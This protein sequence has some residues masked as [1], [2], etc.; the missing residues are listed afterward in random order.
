LS[1]RTNWASG[2][3]GFEKPAKS[4]VF[5][6]NPGKL[7][8]KVKFWNK[9]KWQEVQNEAESCICFVLYDD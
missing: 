6:L 8:Q 5:P 3:S 1:C 9:L 7:F 4:L 2:G